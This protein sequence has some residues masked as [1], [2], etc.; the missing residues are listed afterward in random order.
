LDYV[1][2]RD[3]SFTLMYLAPI[4]VAVWYIGPIAGLVLGF[5]AAACGLVIGSLIGR[6]QVAKPQEAVAAD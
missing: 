6:Q 5:F 4:S 2:G 1:T 3:F